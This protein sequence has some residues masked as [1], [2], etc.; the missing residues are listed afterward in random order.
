[1]LYPKDSRILGWEG[2]LSGGACCIVVGDRSTKERYKLYRN[3]LSSAGAVSKAG[4]VAGSQRVGLGWYGAVSKAGFVI[5]YRRCKPE[6]GVGL[7][8]GSL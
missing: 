2:T 8:W 3:E 7:V 4:L 5:L 6:S 1:M